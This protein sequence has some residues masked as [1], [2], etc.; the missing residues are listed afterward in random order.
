VRLTHPPTSKARGGL[1]GADLSLVEA[2]LQEKV[3]RLAYRATRRDAQKF[4]DGDAVEGR[5]KTTQVLLFAKDANAIFEFVH[6]LGEVRGLAGV[7]R[8]AVT[9]REFIEFIE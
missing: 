8:R 7:A 9:A 5:T 4:H 3:E 1:V 2:D 6:S